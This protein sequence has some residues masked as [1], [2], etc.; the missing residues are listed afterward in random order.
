VFPD[1]AEDHGAGPTGG[2]SPVKRLH[3]VIR[4]VVS[5]IHNRCNRRTRMAEVMS[6]KNDR[7]ERSIPRPSDVLFC[8][9]IGGQNCPLAVPIY[10]QSITPVLPKRPRFISSYA[11]LHYDVGFERPFP[12]LNRG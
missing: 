7:T 5:V 10:P 9:L 6:G 1:N 11:H 8:Y 12:D 4:L 2:T 3:E